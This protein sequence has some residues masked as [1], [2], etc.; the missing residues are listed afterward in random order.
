MSA[1]QDRLDRILSRFDD[2]LL[3][4]LRREKAVLEREDAERHCHV[5]MR[6]ARA[7]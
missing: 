5:A 2:V 6:R 3:E 1:A 4:R 7:V